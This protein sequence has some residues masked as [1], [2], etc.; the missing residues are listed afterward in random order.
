M[1]ASNYTGSL[2]SP[3]Q[4][5]SVANTSSPHELWKVPLPP[6]PL[7]PARP[8]RPHQ[9]EAGLVLGQRPPAP[10][11]LGGL[12]LQ[13]HP[14]VSPG[15]NL[16]K[17][18]RTSTPRLAPTSP[19]SVIN[20]L[21]VNT[22]RDVDLRDRNNGTSSSLN[23]ALPL[24]SAWSSMRASNYTGSLSSPAQCTSVANTSL[25]HELW[26]VP[27]PPKA[28]SG[29]SRPPPGLT[30]QKQAS[31]WDSGPLRLGGW[32]ASDSRFT[33]GSSW[34]DSS[35]GR[36]TNW[37]VL[38]NLT[39]QIDGSTLRT[40]CMQ[41]GPL[42][43]FHLNLPHGNAVVCYSSREE[44]AQA[45]KSLHM[46]VLGNTTILAEFASEEEISRFFAQGQSMAAS[47]GWQSLGAAQSRIGS[48]EGS[49]PFPGRPEPSHWS[50]DLHGSSNSSLWS[51][52]S[53]PSSLWGSPGG[54]EGRGISSPSP[55]GSF[56]PVD[57]LSR[58]GDTM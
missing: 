49:H 41:H 23:T 54:G 43:T 40:L 53:Y 11:G 22:V 33:P 15:R 30:S 7:R 28:P 2:S 8:P 19:G 26:K 52:P 32:G 46:C 37:L 18:I 56:L 57:H 50:E 42:I 38:K 9:P 31:S 3:A 14:R 13:I 58:G 12:G 44:A 6:K 51:T 35:S 24:N 47:P 17:D 16:G 29:P 34:G 36:T 21:S 48:L 10:G 5:T 20:N 27:L 1:R 55:I 39:P 25:A 45:Q 4:C